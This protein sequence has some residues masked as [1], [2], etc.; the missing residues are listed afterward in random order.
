MGAAV[1]AENA[2]CIRDHNVI[3]AASAGCA[4]PFALTLIEA[5]NCGEQAQRIAQQIVIR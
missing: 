2:P 4:I 5:L 3:T 1:M